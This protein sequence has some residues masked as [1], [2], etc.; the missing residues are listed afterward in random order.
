M[1]TDAKETGLT[2]EEAATLIGCSAYTIKELARCRKIPFYKIGSRYM[3]TRSA[4]MTWIAEQE[5]NNC[6]H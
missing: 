1:S 3:F 6:K 4:L 5:M 2:P